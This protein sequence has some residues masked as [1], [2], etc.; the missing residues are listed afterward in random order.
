MSGEI[1]LMVANAFLGLTGT[2]FLSESKIT[3]HCFPSCRLNSTAQFRQGTLHP[4]QQLQPFQQWVL[5]EG[6]TNKSSSRRSTTSMHN[7]TDYF[8]PQL[9]VPAGSTTKLFKKAEST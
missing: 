1:H 8:M 5:I 2:G 6:P 3:Y 7:A 4:F 9:P